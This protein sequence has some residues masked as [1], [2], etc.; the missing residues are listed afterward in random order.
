MDFETTVLSETAK[1]I[2]LCTAYNTTKEK[3]ISRI[4][5]LILDAARKGKT[6]VCLT[7]LGIETVQAVE[8][9]KKNYKIFSAKV[10][11]DKENQFMYYI[12]SWTNAYIETADIFNPIAYVYRILKEDKV[13]IPSYITNTFVDIVT[14]IAIDVNNE[15][16]LSP[17]FSYTYNGR[18]YGYCLIM[19][20]I[21]KDKSNPYVLN[22]K[23]C[24]WGSHCLEIKCG[25]NVSQ[26]YFTSI[27]DIVPKFKE[28]YHKYII[29]K[30]EEKSE[31]HYI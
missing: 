1:N 12:I 18:D 30:G 3:E 25:K 10:R 4:K 20:Y 27:E 17:V 31:F 9:L 13:V 22:F 16:K 11:Y 7:K 19:R 8:W 23:V 24:E 26:Y 15:D 21:P 2:A 6:T 29:N 28:W 5:N 14:Q